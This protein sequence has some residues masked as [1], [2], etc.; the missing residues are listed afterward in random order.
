MQTD[1]PPQYEPLIYRLVNSERPLVFLLGAPLT[2]PRSETWGVPGTIAML[3]LMRENLRGI[4]QKRFD[5]AI[6]AETGN[7]YQRGFEILIKFAGQD[8]ANKVIQQAVL[9]SRFNTDLPKDIP[10]EVWTILE[11]DTR[12]WWIP[13]ACEHLAEL[14]L[15]HPKRFSRVILTTNF[16]PLIEIALATKG[17]HY[18]QST[19]H[20][21]GSI[22]DI[23]G[24]VP[25]VVHL[26]GYWHGNDTLHTPR[27]L[28]QERPVLKAALRK[29]LEGTT[30]VVAAY[31]GWND[32]VTN[33][34]SEVLR[35]HA[36]SPDVI[37]TFYKSDKEAALTGASPRVRSFMKSGRARV[38][39]YFGIDVDTMFSA[40]V[41]AMQT[42]EQVE[43]A[44]YW[45]LVKFYIQ[46]HL[47]LPGKDMI[48]SVAKVTKTDPL[49]HIEHSLD[50]SGSAVK[51]LA[52]GVTGTPERIIRI[53]LRAIRAR[54][55]GIRTEPDVSADDWRAPRINNQFQIAQ[56]E[57]AS[58]GP[59]NRELAIQLGGFLAVH[60]QA[61]A[62]FSEASLGV[63]SNEMLER[64]AATLNHYCEALNIVRFFA[65]PRR[66]WDSEMASSE[67]DALRHSLR[68][69]CGYHIENWFILGYEAGFAMMARDASNDKNKITSAQA[70]VR[71][72]GKRLGIPAKVIAKELESPSSNALIEAA[73][74]ADQEDRKTSKQGQRST[75][76]AAPKT[77]HSKRAQSKPRP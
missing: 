48:K 19:L 53:V 64:S 62:I 8:I 6:A 38:T 75:K 76:K 63:E 17:G 49:R 7:R 18:A 45:L 29:L 70:A 36:S 4:A 23:R 14:I 21:D 54:H 74:K 37:W 25:H 10:S 13:P 27:Q 2:A 60:H 16:D 69:R 11:N 42:P 44:L 32:V 40:L 20:A 61:L 28:T 9:C 59:G 26:H 57:L 51:A 35:D 50:I 73:R 77:V 56:Q 41:E 66:K 58:Q 67:I 65:V 33:A 72:S 71:A 46:Y 52:K 12:G 3:K 43:S 31:S 55:E 1:L 68:E 47:D 34:L 5:E 15:K 30:L 24:T 22:Q 39:P